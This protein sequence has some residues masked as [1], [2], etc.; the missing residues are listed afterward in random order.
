MPV[1]ILYFSHPAFPIKII[2]GVR[3]K[4]NFD[5]SQH[6]HNMLSTKKS[7]LWYYFGIQY[8][9]EFDDCF[10]DYLIYFNKFCSDFVTGVRDLAAYFKDDNMMS[11]SWILFWFN[12]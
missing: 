9:L 12:W 4:N 6:F 3:K 2:I 5:L 11:V 8:Y 7:F 1:I 10:H